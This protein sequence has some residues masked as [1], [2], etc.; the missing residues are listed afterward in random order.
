MWN[1][2]ILKLKKLNKSSRNIQKALRMRWA[3]KRW[4]YR[5]KTSPFQRTD[6]YC[7]HL[8]PLAT[9]MK[10]RSGPVVPWAERNF[11]RG[12]LW[13]FQEERYFKIKIR[14]P[15]PPQKK[16][17]GGS[18]KVVERAFPPCHSPLPKLFKL[19]KCIFLIVNFSSFMK[20][21]K[22]HLWES[23]QGRKI[24]HLAD[25][26]ENT[27]MSTWLLKARKGHKAS[28]ETLDWIKGPWKSQPG[29]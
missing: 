6:P 11:Q 29:Q 18:G 10:G 26:P 22:K 7:L 27:W 1:I 4:G 23:E 20:V 19:G 15:Q 12:R 17:N 2:G 21:E 5:P 24:M 14:A 25:D 28:S 8:P 13:G 16:V 9:Y 3:P